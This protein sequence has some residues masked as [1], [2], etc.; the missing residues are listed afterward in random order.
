M[1]VVAGDE[2]GGDVGRGGALEIARAGA[3]RQQRSQLRAGLEAVRSRIGLAE[4]SLARAERLAEA[5]SAPELTA[6]QARTE[7]EVLR[8]EESRLESQL[9]EARHGARSEE[10]EILTQ[11]LAQAEQQIA[12][13]REGA[14]APEIAVAEAGLEVA[15]ANTALAAESVER[16][17]VT[18][19]LGG[20]VDIVDYTTGEVVPPGAPLLAIAWDTELRVRTFASQRIIDDLAVGDPL[21]VVVDGYPTDAITGRVLRIFDAAEFTDGNVQ[22]PEDRMLLVYRIELGLEPQDSVPVRPG[23]S[24]IVDFGGVAP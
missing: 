11:Q 24:V 23:M 2:V 21:P 3:T 16:C 10:R 9:S 12:M 4:T 13:L 19:P 5:G 18:A 22:T 7:L 17:R 15:Q 20:T 8:A 6:D 14:R 1:G